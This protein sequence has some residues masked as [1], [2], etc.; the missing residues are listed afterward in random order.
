MHGAGRFQDRGGDAGRVLAP[1]HVRD[2]VLH[3]L[4]FRQLPVTLGVSDGCD[5]YSGHAGRAGTNAVTAERHQ[6][7]VN[8]R[9]D[10]EVV[11]RPHLGTGARFGGNFA[12]SDRLL[13]DPNDAGP[14][15]AGRRC[16]EVLS[17]STVRLDRT[18][19]LA[20]YAEF[21]VKHC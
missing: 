13:A 15:L 20:V 19:K 11:G 2:E 8:A 7:R 5:E 12:A 16:G 1:A 21:R 4:L 14:A 3:D 9:P 6:H 17:P 18:D 10:V